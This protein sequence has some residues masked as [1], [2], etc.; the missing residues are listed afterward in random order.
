MIKN[1]LRFSVPLVI[2]PLSVVVSI[3]E[4][5]EELLK[6][7][8]KEWPYKPA[9]EIAESQ[10]FN[11]ST[12]CQAIVVSFP[13]NEICMRLKSKPKSCED[14]GVLAHEIFHAVD[15]VMRKVGMELSPKSHEAYAYLTSYLTTAIYKK[16]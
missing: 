4:T 6:A 9:H 14:Y 10:L 15:F 8:K 1:K 13:N 3:G 2:Y 16:L 12:T 7:L 5:D 11:I